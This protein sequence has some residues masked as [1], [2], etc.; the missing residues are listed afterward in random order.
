VNTSFFRRAWLATALVLP[1]LALA[2]IIETSPAHPSASPIPLG[3]IIPVSWEHTISSQ[4]AQAGQAIEAKIMQDMP[5]PDHGKIPVGA[6]IYGKIL[7]V[8]PPG[9]GSGGKITFRFDQIEFKRD[10]VHV[11]TSLRTMAPFLDVQSAQLSA[12]GSGAFSG[13][14]TT[15]QIGGDIRYGD[16]GEVVTLHKEKVGKGVRDG[17]L[18]HILANPAKGCE[19]PADGNDSPQALWVFSAASCGVYDMKEV[20]ISHSGSTPPLGEIT[21]SRNKD[22]LKIENS[23]GMLLRTVQ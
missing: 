6:K 23:T 1:L 10:T 5:L 16:G 15:S 9:N 21:I 8:V 22:E 11:L 3:T 20:E 12:S 7:S 2:V 19:G 13:W 17:V 4:D 18:V 14:A